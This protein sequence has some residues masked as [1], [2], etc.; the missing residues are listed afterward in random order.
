[1][2]GKDPYSASKAATELI[3]NS[4]ASTCNPYK[5]PVTTVRAGN[6]IGGGDWGEDRLIPDIVRAFLSDQ[7]LTIRN[8]N[9]SRPWQ[10]VLDC[11][12]GYLLTAQSHFNN[13]TATPT[14]INFGPSQ[15]LMVIELVRLFESAFNK[16]I[17]Y[18]IDESNIHESV[19]LELDSKLAYEYLGWE[20]LLSTTDAIK[21]T[22]KWYSDF[23][24]GFNPNE[25]ITNE[26]SK[27]RVGKW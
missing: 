6:V 7:L 10:H 5:I 22:A 8:P 21:N 26:I 3:V 2:G 15:S 4:L 20:T 25:L 1:L 18:N 13:S 17:K 27:Y 9:A 24:A 11:L 12:R 23:I 14:S 16:E 19:W